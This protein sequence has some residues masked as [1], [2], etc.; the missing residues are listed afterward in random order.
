[1]GTAPGQLPF[2]EEQ[3]K[4]LAEMDFAEDIATMDKK[5]KEIIE[6]ETNPYL[7]KRKPLPTNQD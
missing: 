6:D 4:W 3:I 5:K 1:M 2:T 7:K